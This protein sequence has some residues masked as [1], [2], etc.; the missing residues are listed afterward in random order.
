MTHVSIHVVTYDSFQHILKKSQNRSNL[1][2]LD[3]AVLHNIN[4]KEKLSYLTVVNC[5]AFN[6]QW[7]MKLLGILKF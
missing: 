7:P 2:V 6:G 4:K 5:S 1:C 3:N